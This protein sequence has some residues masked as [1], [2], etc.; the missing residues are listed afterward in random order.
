MWRRFLCRFVGCS[1]CEAY[2]TDKGMGGK[3]ADCGRV[4]GWIT[5][6]ELRAYADREIERRRAV[7]GS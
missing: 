2:A 3:C 6:E 5:R 1:R 4:H 7:N